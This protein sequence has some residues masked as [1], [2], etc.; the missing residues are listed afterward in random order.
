[1][2]RWRPSAARSVE[3]LLLEK[4]ADD[5]NSDVVAARAAPPTGRLCK[6]QARLAE[7][8]WRVQQQPHRRGEAGGPR[9]RLARR[10]RGQAPRADA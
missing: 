1:M 8:H 6:W 7:E 5:N 3:K 9:R 10:Q 4:H 2:R